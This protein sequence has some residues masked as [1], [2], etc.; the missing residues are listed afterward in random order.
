MT[1]KYLMN[2]TNRGVLDPVRSSSWILYVV[3]FQVLSVVYV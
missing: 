3:K 2:E 1:I